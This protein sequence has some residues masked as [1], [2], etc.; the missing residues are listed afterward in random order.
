MATQL[1]DELPFTIDAPEEPTIYS[2]DLPI[3]T[4]EATSGVWEGSFEVTPGTHKYV[5]VNM[6]YTS[7]YRGQ[8]GTILAE[9]E[10]EIR[11][12]SREPY[13]GYGVSGGTNA[14]DSTNG[15][16]ISLDFVLLNFT[17]HVPLTLDWSIP[18]KSFYSNY[19]SIS[20]IGL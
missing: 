14:H 4:T 11:D 15:F 10:V 9:M 13:R 16:V 12:W 19:L 20:W 18:L 3:V 17:S 7:N 5:E 1:I 6:C 2:E 8:D